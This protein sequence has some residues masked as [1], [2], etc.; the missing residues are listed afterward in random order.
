MILRRSFPTCRYSKK[1]NKFASSNPVAREVMKLSWV[2][3]TV[4]PDPLNQNLASMF[5]KKKNGISDV[6][7][8]HP[9]QSAKTSRLTKRVNDKKIKKQLPLA[10][11]HKSNV[12]LGYC[13]PQSASTSAPFSCRPII[14]SM[15]RRA[16]YWR[17]WMFRFCCHFHESL[18]MFFNDDVSTQADNMRLH[19]LLTDGR[20]PLKY[21]YIV[22]FLIPNWLYVFSYHYP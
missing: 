19:G 10:Q 13:W 11:L 7:G 5:K 18:Q 15:K 12:D 8:M 1:F 20:N 21:A 17:F 9:P 22:L 14:K 16:D 4:F 3:N 6:W 2:L